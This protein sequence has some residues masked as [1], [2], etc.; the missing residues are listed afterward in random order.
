MAGEENQA[1]SPYGDVYQENKCPAQ[2]VGDE[3]AQDRSR[4]ARRGRDRPD[5]AHHLPLAAGD[6]SLKEDGRAYGE[7]HGG[8]AGL[9][10]AKYDE[11]EQAGCKA[12]GQRTRGEEHEPG[13]KECPLPSELRESPEDEEQT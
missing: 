13:Q 2:G 11:L 1:E 10:H 6:R 4:E 7:Y 5:V 9:D 12:A 8:T 3:T